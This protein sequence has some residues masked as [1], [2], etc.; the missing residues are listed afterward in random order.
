MPGD[1]A[2]VRFVFGTPI[3]PQG[4][5]IGGILSRKVMKSALRDSIR[6]DAEPVSPKVKAPRARRKRAMDPSEAGPVLSKLAFLHLVARLRERELQEKEAAFKSQ[7]Q[8]RK[9][10]AMARRG[11]ISRKTLG[12]WERETP[13][14]KKLPERIHR[15]SAALPAIAA[16]AARILPALG[17][18]LMGMGKSVG[19]SMLWPT[20]KKQ[21]AGGMLGWSALG[22]AQAGA[23]YQPRTMQPMTPMQPMMRTASLADELLQLTKEALEIREHQ[24]ASSDTAEPVVKK[25]AL[26]KSSALAFPGMTGRAT[27]GGTS[28]PLSST[29]PGAS[30]LRK[31]TTKMDRY[32]KPEGAPERRQSGGAPEEKAPAPAAGSH[33]QRPSV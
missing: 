4:A 19:K 27:S 7:A 8:R 10:H 1:D 22:G 12:E 3:T 5:T 13:K 30:W 17:R 29:N 2:F 18:G 33:I 9:F 24:P 28:A 14:G 21:M 20:T 25:N 31:S 26:S 23:S 32:N 11:E 15:K 6:A 16:G